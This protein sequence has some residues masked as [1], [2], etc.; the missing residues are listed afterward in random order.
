MLEIIDKGNKIPFFKTH[1]GVSFSN[2]QNQ[3]ALRSKD[4]AEE[5]ISELLKRGCM[6]K[7]EKSPEVINPLSVSKKLFR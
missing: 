3:S 6:I 1:K 5:S 2:N 4:F 7:V